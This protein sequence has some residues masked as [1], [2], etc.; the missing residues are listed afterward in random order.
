[1][2]RPQR[3]IPTSVPLRS[4][5][6]A[7]AALIA[8]AG[9]V[10]GCSSSHKSASGAPTT[11][12]SSG[13]ASSAPSSGG[14]GSL[15]AITSKL[16]AST[17]TPFDATYSIIGGTG[18]ATTLELAV[19][20]PGKFVFVTTSANGNKSELISAGQLSDSCTEAGGSWTC[21]PLPQSEFA[22]VEKAL[23]IYKS[24]YWTGILAGMQ[25][26]AKAGGIR[27]T[28]S[29]K[30]LAGQNVECVTYSGGTAGS[31][32]EICVTHDGVL[33]YVRSAGTGTTFELS[34]YSS[35]PPASVFGLPPGATV[36]KA[37]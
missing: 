14:A 11:S 2:S 6:V 3:H 29:T 20:P 30:S 37:P 31:G 24:S 4:M 34:S 23:Q 26:A 17:N 7:G 27:V 1:M 19:S 36:T 33:A 16:Q 22:S 25:S 13:S 5:V 35:S 10:A 15:G 9:L 12:T 28:P 21:V 18:Q 8:A 32:G